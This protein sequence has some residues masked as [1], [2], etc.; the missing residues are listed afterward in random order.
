LQRISVK[1]RKVK[2]REERGRKEKSFLVREDER[3]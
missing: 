3:G 1:V 2:K